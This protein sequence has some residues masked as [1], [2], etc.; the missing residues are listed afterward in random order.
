MPDSSDD[1]SDDTDDSDGP[2]LTLKTYDLPFADNLV[3]NW[4]WS[5]YVP[6]FPS[7]E[8]FDTN[9][10]CLPRASISR[11][12]ESDIIQVSADDLAEKKSKI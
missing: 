12:E 10:P 5:K 7:F 4:K 6:I 2:S 1:E 11:D 9:C 8:G 3:R